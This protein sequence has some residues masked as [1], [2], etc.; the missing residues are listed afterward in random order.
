M[1]TT[2]AHVLVEYHKKW[3]VFEVGSITREF[4]T[5]GYFGNLEGDPDGGSTRVVTQ[6]NYE[7]HILGRKTSER[8]KIRAVS[9]IKWERWDITIMEV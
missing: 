6:N 3:N 4:V 7:T 5:S 8:V 1:E 9:G 2:R